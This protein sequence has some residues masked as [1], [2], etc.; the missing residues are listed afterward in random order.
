MTAGQVIEH[1]RCPL[2]SSAW[3]SSLGTLAALYPVSRKPASAAGLREFGVRGGKD[4]RAVS[5]V[6]APSRTR[7]TRGCPWHPCYDTRRERRQPLAEAA[8]GCGEGAGGELEDEGHD[9][10]RCRSLAHDELP[11]RVRGLPGAARTRSCQLS[12]Y[13]FPSVPTATKC[14]LVEMTTL[15]SGCRRCT[16]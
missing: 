3:S 12:W 14:P 13:S 15:P 5:D 1:A 16:T 9:V 2:P 8:L 11:A 6:D 10:I 4:E 7:R